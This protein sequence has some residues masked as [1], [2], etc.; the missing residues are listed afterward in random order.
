MDTLLPVIEE[1]FFEK[2]HYS[3]DAMRLFLRNP[4]TSNL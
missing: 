3:L 4:E 2:T 1:A